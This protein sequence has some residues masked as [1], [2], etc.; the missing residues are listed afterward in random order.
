M[1][2]RIVLKTSRPR[3]EGEPATWAFV[4][5]DDYERL[6]GFTWYVHRNRGSKT[7]YAKGVVDGKMVMMHQAI[8]GKREG[9]YTDHI[10]RNGLNNR[11]K[12]LRFV[13][14]AENINNWL[15]TDRMDGYCEGAKPHCPQEAGRSHAYREGFAKGRKDFKAGAVKSYDE[16]KEWAVASPPSQPEA[17]R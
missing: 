16:I 10:D 5:D 11:K 13:T 3:E 15:R 7:L 8:L 6:S 4:D 1:V 2:K 17:E 9:F 14:P 12:N